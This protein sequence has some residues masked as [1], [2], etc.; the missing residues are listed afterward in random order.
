MK[1]DVSSPVYYT[2]TDSD[3]LG[4]RPCTVLLDLRALNVMK[5][6]SIPAPGLHLLLVSPNHLL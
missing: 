5:G 6:N 4:E 1:N 3:Y 2:Q